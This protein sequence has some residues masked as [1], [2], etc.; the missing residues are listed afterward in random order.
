M[1]PPRCE[2][3][4]MWLIF[5]IDFAFSVAICILCSTSL[6]LIHKGT[7]V[8]VD[9]HDTMPLIAYLGRYVNVTLVFQAVIIVIMVFALVYW[10][11]IY[12]TLLASMG[13]AESHSSKMTLNKWIQLLCIAIMALI[14]FFQFLVFGMSCTFRDLALV[15]NATS[16]TVLITPKENE[17]LLSMLTTICVL[18]GFTIG[19]KTCEVVI[20]HGWALTKSEHSM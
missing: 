6:N 20:G 17:D 1:D 15:V 18:M 11:I 5:A 13:Y 19:L 9:Q 10:T 3:W 2:K 8:D 4:L 16:D 7:P 14:Y 12:R